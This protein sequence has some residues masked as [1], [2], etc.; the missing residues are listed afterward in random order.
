MKISDRLAIEI[1]LLDITQQEAARRC[2][3]SRQRLWDI[4][5][6]RN[7]RFA[8]VKTITDGL[9]LEIG[10]RKRGGGEIEFDVRTF[11]QECEKQNLPFDSLSEILKIM[12]FLLE[13]SKKK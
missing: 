4:L 2:G 10:I 13:V 5:D 3:M 6:K 7:P 11:L 9:G 1:S 8:S 12:G